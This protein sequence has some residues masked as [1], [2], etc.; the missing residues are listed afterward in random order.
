MSESDIAGFFDGEGSAMILTGRVLEKTGWHYR[1]RPTIK[2]SQKTKPVLNKIKD[3]LHYGTICQSK[4]DGCWVYQINGAK[5]L[6]D[7]VNRI[8]P[9]AFLKKRQLYLIK[10][11]AL[12]QV[13]SNLPL[14]KKSIITIINIRDEIFLL[15][16]ITRSNLKQKYLKEQILSEH[17]FVDNIEFEKKRRIAMIAGVKK[18]RK[19]KINPNILKDLYYN[20][21]YSYRKIG[22]IMGHSHTTIRNHLWSLEQEDKNAK[23]KN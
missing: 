19:A 20:R 9:V 3:F 11:I 14:S 16:C 22:R 15:N 13:R 2:I 12:K 7:F 1:F 8:A 10:K 6:I 18:A 5:K 17:A 21:K 23:N 4:S